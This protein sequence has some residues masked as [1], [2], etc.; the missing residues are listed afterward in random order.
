MSC[1]CGCNG[2]C[3]GP[4][5]CGYGGAGS[6][7]TAQMPWGSQMPYALGAGPGGPNFVPG[8]SPVMINRAFV[9]NGGASAPTPAASG[10]SVGTILLAIAAVAAVGGVAWWSYRGNYARRSVGSH[11]YRP[12][13]RRPSRGGARTNARNNRALRQLAPARR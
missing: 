12:R 7:G 8:A 13:S 3:G 10:T 1:G 6:W 11:T 2:A 4:G 9:N 5:C